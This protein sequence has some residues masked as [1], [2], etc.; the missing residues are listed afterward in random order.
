MRTRQLGSAGPQVSALSL[1]CMAMSG[2]YG[3]SDEAESIA[4]IHAAIDQGITMFDTGDFYGMGHN[5][6]LLGRALAGGH[7]DKV[8]L[9]VKFGALR[10]PG[11]AFVGVD[12]RPQ[13][14]QNFLSYT[15]QRLG[16]DYID[17]YRPARVD[18][19][20][21]IED[22]VGAIAELIK[23]G[24]VRYAAL[25]EASAETAARA[26]AAHPVCDVQLEYSIISRGIEEQ[27]LPALRSMG[28]GVTAYGVLSRGLLSGSRP[29]GKGDFRAHLPRFAGA[30]FDQNTALL[31]S[32]AV[33]AQEKG[34]TPSQLA[35][36]WVLAR[37]QQI[38]PLIGSRKRT[39]LTE[40]LGAM[41][42][43]LSAED[44]ARI[45]K[46]VPH[47]EVVGTRYDENQMRMLDSERASRG[48]AGKAAPSR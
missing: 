47:A 13:A 48:P 33:I 41:S 14:V 28:I 34:A 46:A 6:L 12:A 9:S 19:N 21:P 27:L 35:I 25:S 7:R 29:G 4:T 22:T 8:L 17:V 39:Q 18:P 2:M 20:V 40:A 23:A 32:F 37:G 24:Y 36:A 44:L 3:P 38:I 31:K 42:I 16:T 45:D 10:A 43:Q 30:N 15:L 5:E 26:H 11:G 1:V